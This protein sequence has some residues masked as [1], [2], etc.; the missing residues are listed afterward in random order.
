[1]GLPARYLSNSK[2]KGDT[3]LFLCPAPH[4]D[5]AFNKMAEKQ[6]TVGYDS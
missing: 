4:Y 6:K 5:E 2:N 1:M 3:F